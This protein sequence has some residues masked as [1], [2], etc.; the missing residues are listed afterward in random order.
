MDQVFLRGA[1]SRELAEGGAQAF[2]DDALLA[3]LFAANAVQL[4]RCVVGQRA[5]GL[6]FALD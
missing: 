1:V 6:N 5:V 2:F 4:G 3:L